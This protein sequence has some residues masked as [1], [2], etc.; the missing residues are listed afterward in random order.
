MAVFKFGKLKFYLVYWKGSHFQNLY[1][2]GEH[3][4]LLNLISMIASLV[5]MLFRCESSIKNYYYWDGAEW[6]TN[7]VVTTAIPDTSWEA[8]WR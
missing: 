3:T 2:F 4:K 1:H 8:V 5:E 7:K 6:K